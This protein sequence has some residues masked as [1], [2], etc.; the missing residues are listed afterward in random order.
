MSGMKDT[1]LVLVSDCMRDEISQKS[2]DIAKSVIFSAIAGVQE[3]LGSDSL[4]A[5]SYWSKPDSGWVDLWDIFTDY[6]AYEL[7]LIMERRLKDEARTSRQK[8]VRGNI[9]GVV[10]G[11]SDIYDNAKDKD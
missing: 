2:S 7:E 1:Q 5:A 10:S 6:A 11:L 3:S 9:S 8:A 4:R